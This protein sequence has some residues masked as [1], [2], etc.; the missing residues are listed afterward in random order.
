M[1][2][3]PKCNRSFRTQNQQHYCGKAPETIDEYIAEQVEDVQSV[4]HEI[5]KVIHEAIPEAE[6]KIS[7]SM[8]T[9]KGKKNV[10]Q[11]AAF[12]KHVSIFPGPEAVEFFQDRLREYKTSKGT[13]QFPLAKPVPYELIHDIAVWC[14]EKHN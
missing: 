3:C 6:E 7:W 8:P 9:F 4:L 10:I 11:F 14:W 12:K 1:W 2:T 5:Q 13:I